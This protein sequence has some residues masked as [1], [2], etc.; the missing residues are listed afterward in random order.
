M[1]FSE[2]RRGLLVL[3]ATAGAAAPALADNY[4][5]RPIKVIVGFGPGSASDT[6]MRIFAQKLS[7]ALNTPVIVE[8]K[9][10]AGQVAAVRALQAAPADGYTLYL[11]SGSSM[12]QG[13]G[14][15][16]DLPFDPLKDF[17]MISYLADLPGAIIV[18]PGVPARN[19]AELIAHIKA[20]PGQL[21]FG[22]SGVG[23]GGHLAGELFMA[24]TGT[25][26]IHIPYKAD[27]E[28]AK[29]VGAG[30]LQVAF[31]TLRTAAPLHAAGKVRALAV[32]DTRPHAQLPGVPPVTDTPI[33]KDMV[34]YS[35]YALVGSPKL[36]QD[37]VRK[38]SE[39]CAKVAAMPDY[40]AIQQAAG[41]IPG[42]STPAQLRA[43]TE[44]EIVK[45]REVG[46]T[47]KID[48]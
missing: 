30:T 6:F 4:P 32:N 20:N 47:V 33:L 39:A 45:W 9:A 31:T 42:S 3:A 22:S 46:K 16:S 34:P 24:R 35:W 48:F 36:P 5:S 11:G 40:V 37:I 19:I 10:G 1:R 8:N 29:E 38:L 21:N 43:T 7:E 13:P 18:A 25:K 14:L 28:A 2:L 17:G 12:A 23:S 26:M 44:K 41:V 27:T 15:R